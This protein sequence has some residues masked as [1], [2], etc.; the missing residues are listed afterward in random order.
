MN[1]RL[2]LV[3]I[4]ALLLSLAPAAHAEQLIQEFSGSGTT[5]TAE[6]EVQAPWILDW[7][8][9]GEESRVVAVD[10]SLIDANT[11][12]Y[13]GKVL[14]TKNPGN[15]VRLFNEGGRYYFRIDATLMDWTLKVIQLTKEEAEQYKP[16]SKSLLDQ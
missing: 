2:Y 5:N 13:E 14:Q 16:K 4:S 6:F 7:R 8:V 15:G 3:M 11:G 12:A 10:I 9:G 1:N